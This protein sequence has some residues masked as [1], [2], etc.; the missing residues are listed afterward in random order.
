MVS[1][2]VFKIFGFASSKVI[3]P[4]YISCK[5]PQHAYTY[6]FCIFV[7]QLSFQL[8]HSWWVFPDESVRVEEELPSLLFVCCWI[9]LYKDKPNKLSSKNRPS[10]HCN[11]CCPHSLMGTSPRSMSYISS[12]PPGNNHGY[13][14]TKICFV[15]SEVALC[16]LLP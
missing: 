7:F 5:V 11:K 15:S 4:P 16:L 10:K 9:I 6:I 8:F 12:I 3:T 2:P 1:D 13:E 14:L